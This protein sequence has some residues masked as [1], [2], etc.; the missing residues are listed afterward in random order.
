M[1]E[2]PRPH[3]TR[4]DITRADIREVP[5]QQ[6]GQDRDPAA[7]EE[8]ALV[9]AAREGSE[10]AVRELIRRCNG[11]LFRIAR[12][13][14]SSDSDAEEVMQEAYLIAFTRLADFQGRSCFSTW[15][16]RIAINAALTRRRRGKGRKEA[17]QAL[18]ED[19]ASAHI[20]TFPGAQ[21]ELPEAAAARS[22]VRA[23]L[24]E[25][26]AELP[27]ELRLP[28]LLREVEGL[29]ILAI[30]RILSLNPAT[31]KTR[32]F[33]AR[34]RLRAALNKRLKDGVDSLLPF[35]GARCAAMAD[36]VVTRLKASGRN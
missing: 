21:T 19:G 5:Q 31:V 29:S 13:I 6:T 17:L 20:L 10:T 32:L 34:R 26:V 18:G 27:P 35:A 1:R 23:L 16:T 8:E 4:P 15:L 2:P 14:L 22:Q 36:A 3:I 30:A 9:A 33:R 28:F 7:W 12:G 11:R 25:A 24:E